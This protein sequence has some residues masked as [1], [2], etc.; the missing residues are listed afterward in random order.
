[1][2]GLVDELQSAIGEAM[3]GEYK[4]QV[5][6]PGFLSP[7]LVLAVLREI[8]KQSL[9]VAYEAVQDAKESGVELSYRNPE[10]SSLEMEISD[11]IDLEKQR[12]YGEFGLDQ[13]EDSASC[14]LYSAIELYRAD[15]EFE[16][17]LNRIDEEF[18][19]VLGLI[20]RDSLSEEL[21]L[22]KLLC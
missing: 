9:R 7:K 18:Q 17:E 2:K 8:N 14:L 21:A 6:L 16:W 13:C 11:S 22:S 4:R 19:R 15:R 1:M 3:L 10:Y 20:M 5:N 12:V